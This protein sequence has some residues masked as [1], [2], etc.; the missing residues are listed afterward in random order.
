M[1]RLKGKAHQRF[2]RILPFQF[3]MVR[4]K[5]QRSCGNTIFRNISIP[6]GSIKSHHST[7]YRC[8]IY[9]ISIPYGSIKSLC[10]HHPYS[11]TLISIPY[12]SIKSPCR[13]PV[14]LHHSEFQ[15]L[16]VRLKVGNVVV[17][18]CFSKFQFLMVRLKVL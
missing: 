17:G 12:G 3:L 13:T 5:V 11:F 16:M 8:P 18:K 14:C 10:V 6:Y 4:L 1:V 15:F 9:R 7:L 2:L